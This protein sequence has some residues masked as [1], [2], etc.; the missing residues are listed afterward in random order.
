MERMGISRLNRYLVCGIVFVIASIVFF[1]L[2]IRL[3]GDI[4]CHR[5]EAFF[6]QGHIGLAAY[7]FEKAAS[8]QSKNWKIFKDLSETHL[9][10]SQI[11][12]G[13]EDSFQSAQR[14]RDAA[15]KAAL[16][17]PIDAEAFYIMALAEA[18]LEEL[19]ACRPHDI[20]STYNPIPSFQKAVQL[21]PNGIL[22]RYSFIRYLNT[23]IH[24]VIRH[25]ARRDAGEERGV[26]PVR[27]S[28]EPRSNAA[29]WT[30]DAMYK[31]KYS[32][33]LDEVEAL[34]CVYPSSVNSLRNEGLW[35]DQVKDACMAGLQQAINRGDS[36][37]SAHIILSSLFAEEKAW[38]K[39]ISHYKEALA[40]ES[41]ANSNYDFIELGKLYVRKGD[42]EQGEVYLLQ[43]IQLSKTR[44]QDLDAIYNFFRGQ[45]R[46]CAGLEFLKKAKD[47][48]YPF[49]YKADLVIAR[50]LLDLRRYTE[51][52]EMLSEMNERMPMA[53]TYYWL[54]RVAE[55]EGNLD[56]MELAIQRATVEDNKNSYYHLVFSE[57]LKRLGKL[58]RA[59]EE[60][61]LAIK[62]QS[63]KSPG[64]YNYRAWLRWDK[65]D[66][67][68]AISDWQ[69]SVAMQPNN[70][71]FYANMS[72]A[73]TEL[74]DY[75]S[76]L[77]YY[78]Y[79]LNI[80][81]GNESYKQ[82]VKELEAKTQR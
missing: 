14:A 69:K 78:R 3:I 72:E 57:L 46:L 74:G 40:Y 59:E 31:K 29:I 15:S 36:L 44:D 10:L 58:D 68:G 76:A 33:M 18:R 79:A 11:K 25:S 37:R 82:K 39:A 41:H 67:K 19:D 2:S 21:R 54:A 22:F 70:A 24:S 35:S 64:I 81:S 75:A 56:E 12:T 71:S 20:K 49:P 4:H 52:K 45:N 77:R 23:T 28:D 6:Q 1:L 43:G 27:C 9:K 62:C 63:D 5:A 32:R 60:A 73:Y 50:C 48:I 61:G 13:C 34:A 7:H 53:E 16:L 38:D 8:Y 26:L 30:Y 17:N 66:Y 80:D 55:Q 51:A 42:L 47:R 65:M